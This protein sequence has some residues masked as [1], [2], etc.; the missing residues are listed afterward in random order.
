[1]RRSEERSSKSSG[2]WVV[3]RGPCAALVA[4]L[5]A[6]GTNNTYYEEHIH[7]EGGGADAG[8][9]AQEPDEPTTSGD[10]DS[11]D[12][13]G[14][15]REPTTPAA[16]EGLSPVDLEPD[17]EVPALSPGAPGADVAPAALAIDVFGT[18]G[19]HYWF[20]AS[21]AQVEKMNAPYS[22]GF[23]GYGD[24]Y[25]PSGGGSVT[26]VDHLFV[27]TAGEDPHTA[28]F[29]K[30]Q[31]RLVG[32]S[33]GRPWTLDS[34][35][36][37]KIDSDEFVAGNR[38]GGV[39]HMR[40]NNAVVGSIFREKLTLDLYRELGYPAPQA[41]YAWVSGSVWGPSIDVPYIAVE[42]YKPQF[43]KLR[44]A[45]LGG[46]CVNM[47][48]F[49]GD[50]GYGLLGYA[51]NC[52]FSECDPTRALEFE[53]DAIQTPPGPGFKE[54]L[55]EWLDWDA[56]HEFQCLSWILA[57]GDDALHNQNNFVLMERTDGKFQHLPYSIDISLG[58]EWYPQVPLAGGNLLS[59]G[60]Q[61]DPECWDDTLA[62]CEV[63]VD[64]F[65]DLNPI[66]MLDQTYALLSQQGMLR[67]GDEDRYRSLSSYLARRIEELPLELEQNRENGPPPVGVFCEYPYIQCG[68]VCM[69][70]EECYLCEPDPD[71]LPDA[72]VGEVEEAARG[73]AADVA[74]PDP[75]VPL[76]PDV[77][78]PQQCLPPIDI[79]P[80]PR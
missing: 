72:G 29:G 80:M 6:C 70:P 66:A 33:T 53:L 56:F 79:Y 14:E 46:G 5:A 40:L 51:E 50:L 76:P 38:I 49:V 1:M 71:P 41:T 44:E 8:A 26:F 58:Q 31:V 59:Q 15:G 27:T 35:P 52:Q 43:C 17:G 61:S 25:T 77:P 30:V 24:I 63:L 22:G 57:T 34:L 54:T 10:P 16:S 28:D 48:E 75:G 19:N 45:E 78:P 18:L 69:L 47:W 39:K 42:S 13:S 23:G 68:D 73:A 21:E 3:G 62:M 7:I 74:L 12:G 67:D 64:S 2:R 65:I 55:S 36:N 32:Q 60:C 11:G 4:L 9:P 20:E 37:F